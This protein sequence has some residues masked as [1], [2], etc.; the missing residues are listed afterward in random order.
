[1]TVPALDQDP[2]CALGADHTFVT[3]CLTNDVTG[4]RLGNDA[5]RISLSGK[6]A[7]QSAAKGGRG[8]RIRCSK[9]MV[10]SRGD[11][12]SDG[13]QIAYQPL[14]SFPAPDPYATL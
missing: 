12:R 5:F 13:A 3:G 11:I 14:C 1:M 2:P 9:A 10:G 8:P 4:R 6:Y 7:A